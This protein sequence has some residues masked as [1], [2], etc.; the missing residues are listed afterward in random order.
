LKVAGIGRLSRLLGQGANLPAIGH[1]NNRSDRRA[2]ILQGPEAH[3]RD[4]A[5]REVRQAEEGEA[6]LLGDAQRSER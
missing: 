6:D 4:R 1:I 2:N 3:H 5:A